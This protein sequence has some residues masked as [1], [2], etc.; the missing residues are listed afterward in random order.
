MISLVVILEFK[1]CTLD[2]LVTAVNFALIYIFHI[3]IFLY[4]VSIFYLKL[5]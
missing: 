2:L 4:S 5:P 1:V 3:L